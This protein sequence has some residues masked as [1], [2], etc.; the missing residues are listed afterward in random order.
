ML[1]QIIL[2]AY[3]QSSR[4]VPSMQCLGFQKYYD[5]YRY[6]SIRTL[7]GS[8]TVLRNRSYRP[9]LVFWKYYDAVVYVQVFKL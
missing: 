7:D 3:E 4:I 1:W 2:E 9:Y 6:C 8:E 5:T